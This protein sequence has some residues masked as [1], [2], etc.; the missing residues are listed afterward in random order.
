MVDIVVF[1]L[2]LIICIIFIEGI[3]LLIFLVMMILVFV[4]VLKERLL[5]EVLIIVW[6]I[7]LLLWLRII[8]FYD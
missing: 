8:G 3:N 2:E 7:F 5:Y 6:C 1:V 4:G